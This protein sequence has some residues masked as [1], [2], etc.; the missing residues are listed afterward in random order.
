M[1]LIQFLLPLYDNEGERFSQSSYAQ[2]RAE[3]TERFGGMTAYAQAP[4]SGLWR[5]E[6][7]EVMHDELVAHEVM[8]ETLDSEWWRGYRQS[9]EARFRQESIV[10][11]AH[12]IQML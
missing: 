1:Y 11:R 6:E 8:A 12:A 10:I 2:V 7:G 3:L 5:Q 9:L 4:A